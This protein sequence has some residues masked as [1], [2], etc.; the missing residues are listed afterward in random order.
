VGS[1][2]SVAVLAGSPAR[3][4]RS[5]TPGEIVWLAA[6]PAAVLGV[7]AILLLGPPI[8][9][10]LLAQR[11]VRFWESFQAEVAPEPV[12]QGRFLV[13]LTIPLLLAGLT[14]FGVRS[15]RLWTASR[16]TTALVVAAQ[17]LLVA[18]VV[19][20]RAAQKVVPVFVPGELEPLLIRYFTVR[21]LVVAAIATAA[22]VLVLR[23][24]GLRTTLR[25]ATRDTRPSTLAAG[26][27]AIVAIAVWLL[28]AYNTETTLGT[29]HHEVW[30]H[31]LFTLDETFAVLDGRSPLVDFAAQYGSLFPYAFAAG[32]SLL[33]E[34]VGVWIA[35]ALIATG[36]GMLAIYA[37][38][39]R[40]AGS[41]VLGLLLFLPV[42][43]TSF[44]IVEGTLENRYTFATY[45][46][47]F[48]MRYA[49]PSLLVWLVA[50]RLS[51]GG[52]AWP[53]RWSLVFLAAGIVVLNNA[54]VG[55]PALGG[56]VAAALWSSARLESKSLLR[57]AREALLG[58]AGAFALVA[59]LTLIRTGEL[60]HLELL[61]RYSWLF[62]SAGFAMFPM[63]SVGLHL[64]IYVTFVA[65]LGVATARA[66]RGG[67]EDRLLTG[68]LAWSG[69]FGLGAGAYYVGRSTPDDLIAIF[70][71]WSFAVALLA[72]CAVRGLTAP[73]WRGSAV[74]SALCLFGF[75]VAACSLAQ[76]P[77]PWEQLN[78]LETK[79]PPFLARAPG[80]QLVAERARRGEPV[81]ILGP[82]GHWVGARL[83]V[84]NVSPYS[85]SLSMPAVEQLTE[86]LALLR[87]AGG[88]KV[89]LNHQDTTPEMQVVMTEA[90][91]E[92]EAE[93]PDGGTMMWVDA[94]QR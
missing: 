57:L 47:T 42:L 64:V 59:V 46:G 14:L 33:G 66:V 89:F 56:T 26:A 10:A 81:L 41:A 88:D 82:L 17:L 90:G 44:F 61:F 9:N 21:T 43:A 37:V 7:A 63:P 51:G 67:D 32:M 20:A 53:R 91:F 76:T 87:E 25:N 8:G 55:I 79:S 85:G 31:A 19:W 24:P 60:P 92:F 2:G 65:A 1:G 36:L 23:R 29:T 3:P 93:S 69:V 94:R 52:G 12:E 4:S 62:A 54:D 83:G 28:H 39:R 40:V 78:R 84:R 35:L 18:F 80:Q 11:D 45:F 38:L 86:T 71:P 58:L 75:F 22:A 74:A 73:A 68:L 6:I 77:T 30:Y 72:V 13:A 49:G 15:R 48:P 70:F 5:L 50:R 27:I 16:A 34:S